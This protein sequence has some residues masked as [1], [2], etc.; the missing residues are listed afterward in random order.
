MRDMSEKDIETAALIQ[1][2]KERQSRKL[3]LIAAENYA[4]EQVLEA[5]GSVLTN[6]YAEGYPGRRYY[7]GCQEIDQVERL[8]VDRAKRLFGAEH[9]NVQP[10]SGTQA[11]LAVYLALLEYGDTVMSMSLAHGGHLSHGSP[12]SLSGKWY[13]FVHYGVNRETELLDYD[14]I[15]RLAKEHRPKLIV[16]GA[17]SYPRIIDCQRLHD[18]GAEVE[19][20]LMVDMAHTA[21]LV[22]AGVHPSPVPWAEV[23]TSTTHKTLRGPRGGFI[24][25]RQEFAGRLDPAVFPGTQGGPLMHAIAGKAIAFHEAMQ[26]DFVT[27]QERVLENARTLASE[28]TRLGFRLVTGGTDS[29]L[30]LIDLRPLGITGRTAEEVLDSVGLSANRNG[31]P[32]DP[33]PPQTTSG[34][35]L[36]TPAVT[37]RGLGPQEMR[38]I[39]S[40]IHRVLT[41]PRD[42]RVK[43]QA[44]GEVEG[45]CRRFP[46]H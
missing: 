32:F 18:I 12:A 15:E 11:N 10:H 14:E 20:L 4:G 22:A 33:L 39:A 28:L 45:I 36:G 8:A 25:S 24:L 43:S 34:L 35:R 23:V 6:K 44:C 17:S 37:T 5:Q 41:S 1:R 42:E 13:R 40:L 38:Q 31:I 16:A 30:L 29:H 21:G 19:A 27:Y 7:G 46:I 26:P 3:V 2:E 9:A